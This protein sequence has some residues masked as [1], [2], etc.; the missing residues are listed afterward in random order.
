MR[1]KQLSPENPLRSKHT[2]ILFHSEEEMQPPSLASA[3]DGSAYTFLVP[4]GKQGGTVFHVETVVSPAALQKGLSGRPVLAAGHGM[5]FVFPSIQR[6]SMWMPEMQFPLDIAWLDD[7]FVV[8]HVTRN[9][10]PCPNRRECPSYGSEK[11]AKYAIEMK[12][13]DAAAYGF[14]PGVSL[15][16][17]LA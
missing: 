6:H 12:A 7:K 15:S 2:L 13:G 11:P 5:L 1:V 9:A 4:S 16:V 17:S 8:V 14:R 10:S 3:R